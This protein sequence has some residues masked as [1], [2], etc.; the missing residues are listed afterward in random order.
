V[1]E[2]LRVQD[3]KEPVI[4]VSGAAG[5]VGSLVGQ[6]AKRAGASVVIGSAGGPV[7]CKWYAR[8]TDRC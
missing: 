3:R 8:H 7:K 6:L 1:R 2:E 5:A 4:L